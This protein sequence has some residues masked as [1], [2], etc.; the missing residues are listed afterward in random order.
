MHDRAQA[1]AATDLLLRRLA[2]LRWVQRHPINPLHSHLARSTGL[3]IHPRSYRSQLAL[4]SDAEVSE[5]QMARCRLALKEVT[6]AALLRLRGG[7]S[8]ITSRQPLTRALCSAVTLLCRL[9]FESHSCSR[10]PISNPW[11]TPATGA[12]HA[13]HAPSP[14][15]ATH[16]S[17]RPAL[18]D[19]FASELERLN[20]QLPHGQV[21]HLVFSRAFWFLHKSKTCMS[22]HRVTLRR[23]SWSW[24]SFWLQNDQAPPLH[25]SHSPRVSARKAYRCRL[26]AGRSAATA[27]ATATQHYCS[28][29]GNTARTPTDTLGLLL[30]LAAEY[31]SLSMRVIRRF[32]FGFCGGGAS[33]SL[34]AACTR[35]H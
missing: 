6:L 14:A 33:S 22:L 27:A 12:C 5:D 17:R 8:N 18:R 1:I 19:A 35:E 32:C 28:S 3:L 20:N 30:T 29:N 16:F 4:I 34:G 7:T 31:Y 10:S 15:T 23:R 13:R 9:P 26:P 2:D 11:L 25:T 21:P 24:S